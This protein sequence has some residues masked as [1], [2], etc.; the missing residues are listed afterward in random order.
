MSKFTGSRPLV[1]GGNTSGGTTATYD[2]C[3]RYDPATRRWTQTPSRL[4]SKRAHHG[5]VVHPTLGLV[6]TGGT[7]GSSILNTMESTT[8]GATFKRDFARLPIKLWCHCMVMVNSGKIMAFG[9][10]TATSGGHSKRAFKYLVGTNTWT[11]V[12][13]MTI[14]RYSPSC[15]YDSSSNSVIVAGGRTPR[16]TINSVEILDITAMRWRTGK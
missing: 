12:P 10:L 4:S 11:E 16:S 14:A 3:W 13:S 15:G 8:D 5:W 1:C 2:Q 7:A 9:G 6:M